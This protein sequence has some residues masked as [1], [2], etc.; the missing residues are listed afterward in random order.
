MSQL[1][2]CWDLSQL[3]LK[4][5]E[6][7]DLAQLGRCLEGDR[8]TDEHK[9]TGQHVAVYRA[10]SSGDNVRCAALSHDKGACD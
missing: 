7:D 1:V 10:Q 6:I 3:M 2:E 5:L 8:E 9:Q 4:V